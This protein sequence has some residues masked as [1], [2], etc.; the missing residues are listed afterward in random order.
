MFVAVNL[1]HPSLISMSKGVIPLYVIILVTQG[2]P[3]WLA[4][5][6]PQKYQ[7]RVKV[8]DTEQNARLLWHGINYDCKKFCG[9]AP[10]RL[11]P[12]QQN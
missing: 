7:T 2:A 1:F 12:L 6:L 3:L 9:E 8:T 11:F 10:S 5:V 4:Q